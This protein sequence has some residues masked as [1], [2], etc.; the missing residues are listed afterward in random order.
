MRQSTILSLLTP[1][2]PGRH[3]F[4]NPDEN[5]LTPGPPY[6]V[7]TFK[8]NSYTVEGKVYLIMRDR[9]EVLA[10][11]EDILFCHTLKNLIA[12]YLHTKI[13]CMHPQRSMIGNK[14]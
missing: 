14:S 4:Y 8:A 12:I 6:P 5:S 3:E 9:K 10:L 7:A 1:S 2:C 11:R 13:R